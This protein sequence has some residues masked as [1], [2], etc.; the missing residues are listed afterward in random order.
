VVL[1]PSQARGCHI[2]RDPLMCQTQTLMAPVLG[3]GQ[4]S[5]GRPCGLLRGGSVGEHIPRPR[6]PPIPPAPLLPS[7]WL[8]HHSCRESGCGADESRAPSY[9]IRRVYPRLRADGNTGRAGVS[10]TAGLLP[11][12]SDAGDAQSDLGSHNPTTM[13]A[14]CEDAPKGGGGQGGVRWR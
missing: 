3:V 1:S 9:H 8:R 6:P 13:T 5:V 12:H 7:P 14:A 11:T 4:G 10:T 2:E